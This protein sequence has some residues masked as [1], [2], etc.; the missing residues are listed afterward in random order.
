MFI[1]LQRLIPQHLLSRFV[2]LFANSQINWVKHLLIRFIVSKYHVDMSE[3][4]EPDMDRYNCFNQ[5][6]TRKL[7][8]ESRHISGQFCSPADGKVSASGSIEAN[9]IFQAKG[10]SYSLEKLL[11]TKDVSNYVDGS[12]FTVYLS[13]KD[14]HRVHCPKGGRLTKVRYIPG[15]LFSVN[16]KTTEEVT[17]LFAANE[18]MV[19][20]FDL[21]DGKMVVIM[22]GAMIVAAIQPVWRDQP[23]TARAAIEEIFDPPTPFNIGDEL[24]QFQ[25]GSTA[26]ILLDRKVNWIK[27]AGAEIRMGE[28]IVPE[29]SA[30]S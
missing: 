24:G 3:A 19:M 12:F 18:R 14:Y 7:K 8:P 2:G 11:A 15:S 23:Y 1:L 10:I 21:T 22:V 6:F 26:I 16:Q 25:M 30:E 4:L 28:P 9:M 20:E 5:F 17:D 27:P 29:S 13:P